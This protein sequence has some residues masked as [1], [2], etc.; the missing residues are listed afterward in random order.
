MTSRAFYRADVS[1]QGRL[2]RWIAVKK[3]TRRPA[4]STSVLFFAWWMYSMTGANLSV[5]NLTTRHTLFADR[6]PPQLTF[7]LRLEVTRSTPSPILELVPTPTAASPRNSPRWLPFE[8][9]L[10]SPWIS[11]STSAI[12]SFAYVHLPSLG[13][14]LML[15]GPR[16]VRQRDRRLC[17]FVG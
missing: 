13:I 11:S 2:R 7:D 16:L 8:V 15:S 5:A 17:S 4:T 12:M 3:Q 14:P 9:S 10:E 6:P 1:L